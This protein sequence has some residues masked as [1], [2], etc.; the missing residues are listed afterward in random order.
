MFIAF[1]KSR[2]WG[3]ESDSGLYARGDWD[4][5]ITFNASDNIACHL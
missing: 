5:R 1:A 2:V 4:S 3:G